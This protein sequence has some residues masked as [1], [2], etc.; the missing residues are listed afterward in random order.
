[1][2][3]VNLT[4]QIRDVEQINIFY[5]TKHSDGLGRGDNELEPQTAYK[6]KLFD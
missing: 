5:V 3:R 1:M 6:V 4:S 2:L